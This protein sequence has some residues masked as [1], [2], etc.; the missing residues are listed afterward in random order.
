M[1]IGYDA[2]RIFHNTTGLGN[3]SRD[4][5]RI[6]STFYP[7]N[8]YLL[9]NPKPG[10]VTRLKMDAARIKEILPTSYIAK[11]LHF[12]WRS[13][14]IVKQ[15]IKDK[16]DIYHGLTGELP[17]GIRNKNIKSVVTI[18]D[19]IFIRYPELYQSF[20]RR[21][22]LKKFKYA[23][24]TADVVIAISEQTKRDVVDF[25]GINP[26]KIQ[27]IYQGCHN[28][29]KEDIS[30]SFEK[31]VIKKYK[32]PDSFILNVGAVNERKN[33]LSLVKAIEKTGD[34]LVIVGDGTDYFKKVYNWVSKHHL[35]HRV[36]FLKSLSMY[37]IVVLYRKAKLFVYPSIFE[38]FG[39]PIIEALYS[40]TPVITSKGSCFPEAGGADSFYLNNPYD[41]A[42]L[43][44][45]I[46]KIATDNTYRNNMIERGF[47][48]VQ[49]FNDDRIAKNI[50]N[51]YRTLNLSYN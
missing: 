1:I 43:K 13:N 40:K 24:E 19:L 20:D 17:Y 29:F 39:I 50:M 12:L 31:K 48:F 32:L 27:V 5:V 10:K 2:K 11:K 44:R 41:V 26:D 15:L 25:L 18:H 47:E 22:Y 49:K 14:W 45:A 33:V 6:L 30:V 35:E 8:K 51:L 34:N 46:E 28:A 3:Y 36:T 38:G 42:E 21:I 9:Y 4:L 37:E 16:I 23:A 7:K